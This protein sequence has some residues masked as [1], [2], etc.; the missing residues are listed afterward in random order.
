MLNN[1]VRWKSKRVNGPKSNEWNTMVVAFVQHLFVFLLATFRMFL[2]ASLPCHAFNPGASTWIGGIPSAR[3]QVW[4]I[5]LNPSQGSDLYL[6]QRAWEICGFS[7]GCWKRGMC[8]FLMDLIQGQQ[9]T[10]EGTNRM[11]RNQFFLCC[12]RW[13][14]IFWRSTLNK[15]KGLL[16]SWSI[17]SEREVGLRIIQVQMYQTN[18]AYTLNFH[19]IMCQLY[20]N[21]SSN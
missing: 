2:W 3:Y 9:S 19:N 7:W 5:T 20:L 21:K 11:T 13:R 12:R 15:V 1:L 14:Y 16:C 6:T 4:L 10:K 17:L 18:I 8:S